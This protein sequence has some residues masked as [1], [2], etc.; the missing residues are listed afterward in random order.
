MLKVE[1]DAKQISKDEALARKCK[2]K[3]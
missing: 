3:L 1:I 2:G